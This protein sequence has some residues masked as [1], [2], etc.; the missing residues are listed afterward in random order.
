MA[1]WRYADDSAQYLFGGLD[2]IDLDPVAQKILDA[3]ARGPKTQTEIAHLF[4]RNLP[5]H[6]LQ[7]VLMDLQERG[8]INAIKRRTAG[9]PQ[10][11]WQMMP[12]R[13]K[14]RKKRNKELTCGSD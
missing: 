2:D 11:V 8:L 10:T 7:K 1:I 3:I 12:P 4:S 14:K 9:R 6:K 5:G 13:E